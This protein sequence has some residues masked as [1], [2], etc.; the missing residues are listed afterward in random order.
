M[1]KDKKLK[2][3]IEAVETLITKKQKNRTIRSINEE[4]LLLTLLR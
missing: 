4:A 2:D 3:V 1:N